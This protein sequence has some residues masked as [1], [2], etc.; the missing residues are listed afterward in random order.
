MIPQGNTPRWEGRRNPFEASIAGGWD[1]DLIDVPS[2]NQDASALIVA[3]V[4]AVREACRGGGAAAM[5]STSILLMGTAGAGKTHLFDRLRRQLTRRVVLVLCRSDAGASGSPRVVLISAIEALQRRPP[6]TQHRQS[7]VMAGALLA[8]MAGRDPD[9]PLRFIKELAAAPAAQRDDVI[10]DAIEAVCDR[11]PEVWPAYLRRLLRLPFSARLERQAMVQWLAGREPS[12]AE[13]AALG[14][15]EGIAEPLRALQT[16]G[17][18]ASFGS[19]MV[20]FFD[21]L[22]N[23]VQADGQTDRIRDY[24]SLL[25]SLRDTVRGL[26]IVQMA[27]DTEWQ[28]RIRPC[29][30]ASERDRAEEHR[31]LLRLPTPAEC[32]ELVRLRLERLPADERRGEFPWPFGEEQLAALCA[33]GMTPRQLVQSCYE[34]LSSGSDVQPAGAPA[35][36][37]PQPAGEGPEAAL[38][39]L[40]DAEPER[41]D[42]ALAEHW[43]QFLKEA[44]GRL[45]EA[46]AEDRGI[47][48]TELAQGLEASLG[49]ID[50][51]R[52]AQAEPLHNAPSLLVRG[53]GRAVRLVLLQHRAP[54]SLVAVLRRAAELRTHEQL[55]LLREASL[56]LPLSWTAARQ[57]LATLLDSGRPLVEVA[58]EDV[59]RVLGAGRLRSAAISRDLSS[60]DGSPIDRDEALAWARRA[61]GCEQWEI[62]QAI[63]AAPA[64]SAAP[65]A[66][67]APAASAASAASAPAPAMAAP[68]PALA[69]S[70]ASTAPA[71]Q[72]TAQPARASAPARRGA[73]RAPEQSADISRG[74]TGDPELEALL[75]RLRVASVERLVRELR[76]GRPGLT[77]QAMA[78]AL[79]GQRV[80][81][82]GRSLVAY[83]GGAR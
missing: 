35:P 32:R 5:Q 82:L 76:A 81:W 38:A 53:R 22:E 78:Q 14:E 75:V 30:M 49:L 8:Q 44:R 31:R 2:L 17:V 18:V 23:L 61:L 13:A 40:A 27:L 64:A 7:D 6:G 16:L 48:A 62:I 45:D 46:S 74:K 37:G 65:A 63:L 25:A 3:R 1:D 21:Q 69:S 28:Q 60:A 57:L 70:P 33:A 55:V 24:A 71:E 72:Q 58:R 10:E 77:R 68:A 4:E 42:D 56:S 79:K 41:R 67:A 50:G 39:A 36:G 12:E 34:L 43:G 54:Q 29:L 59:A 26:V 80:E 15:R 52:V 73:R 11:H 20:I 51:V 19:P 47:D 83:R 9:W 66:P